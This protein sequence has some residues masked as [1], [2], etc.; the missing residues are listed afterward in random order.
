MNAII[1]IALV[2]ALSAAPIGMTCNIE[3]NG[4]VTLEQIIQNSE[5]TQKLIANI[6]RENWDEPYKVRNL[7]EQVKTEVSR[8]VSEQ[9]LGYGCNGTMGV[10]RKALEFELTIKGQ[11][12]FK[13]G[14]TL[15]FFP[16]EPIKASFLR[17][18]DEPACD[19]L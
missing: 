14:K 17:N 16:V 12:L 8:Q 3:S 18:Y 7:C 19:P 2:N 13:S 1:G 5:G 15:L 11:N 6:G 4:Y 9:W 10:E